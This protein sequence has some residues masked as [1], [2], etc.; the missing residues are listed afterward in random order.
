[1]GAFDVMANVAF[2][3]ASQDDLLAL[4]SVLSSLYPVVTVV[5]AWV[6]LKER[7][8][9]I[10]YFGVVFALFGVCQIALG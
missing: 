4:V 8:M 9:T 10:Q 7:L 3:I 6:I 1:V 5:M 2:T